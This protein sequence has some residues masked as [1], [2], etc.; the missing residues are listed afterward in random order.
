M[1]KVKSKFTEYQKERRLQMKERKRSGRATIKKFEA[2]GKYDL[3][4][5]AEVKMAF[6][7]SYKDDFKEEQY[8]ETNPFDDTND[9]ETQHEQLETEEIEV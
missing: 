3:E 9:D 6:F 1:E 5:I 8:L 7:E 2:K 4:D